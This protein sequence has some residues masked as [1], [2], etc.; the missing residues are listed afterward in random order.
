MIFSW[1]VAETGGWGGF[2]LTVAATFKSRLKRKLKLAATD[3]FKMLYSTSKA[4]FFRSA[5][6]L[7]QLR[8]KSTI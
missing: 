2:K 7:K 4:Q 3:L 6:A 5:S 8:R 1:I